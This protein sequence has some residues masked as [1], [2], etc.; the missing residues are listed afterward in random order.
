MKRG[1]RRLFFT[2][3]AI[4]LAALV[5]LMVQR[6][7]GQDA[8]KIYR[9]SVLLDGSDSERWKNFRAGL[10]RAAQEWNVDLRFVTRYDESVSQM[11]ALR[12]EWEGEAE[13]VI[14][15]PTDADALS[16]ALQE[17]PAGLAVSVVG[18]KLESGRVAAYV[19]PNYALAGEQLADAA[20]GAGEG[21]T[22]YL[23]P[24]PSPA[25]GEMAAGLEDALAKRGI[26]CRRR[27]V[28]E[29]S[30]PIIAREGALVAVEPAVAQ[31]LCAVRQSAG[32][33]YAAGLSEGLLRA[34]ED[35][36][37]AALVVQSDFDAGYLSLSRVVARLSQERAED[38]ILESYI[39]TGENMFQYPMSN[40]LFSAY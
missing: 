7:G 33:V 16:A 9:V 36:T 38:V 24:R 4:L 17:A 8:P 15:I 20:A 40:I 2:V 12:R 27:T 13:G 25:A 18:A 26:P 29:G 30:T 6:V 22:L 34:L 32:R 35:G 1:E 37:A 10:Q 3:L 23:S 31:A 28:E 19:S 21:V 5:M 14:L 39:A 11:D